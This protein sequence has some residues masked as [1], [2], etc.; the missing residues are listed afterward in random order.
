[1]LVAALV[2]DE[3]RIA[4]LHER[5]ALVVL[6]LE[7]ARHA[8]TDVHRQASERAAVLDVACDGTDHRMRDGHVGRRRRRE[9]IGDALL[10]RGGE[11]QRS[12]DERRDELRRDTLP[13]PEASSIS[14]LS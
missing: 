12:R 9:G 11:R 7:V 10:A 1:G 5:A 6:L 14:D 13:P 3:E 4:L 8:G 2:D